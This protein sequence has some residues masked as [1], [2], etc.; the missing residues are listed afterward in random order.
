MNFP[1]LLF[2][3]IT[4]YFTGRGLIQLCK[5]QMRP[6]LL[7]CFSMISGVAI[8]SFLPFFIELLHIPITTGSVS[9]SIG[10]VTLL[11]MIPL[12]GIIK[13]FKMPTFK[14]L[15]G[16]LQLY[17][18][19]FL[20]IFVLLMAL[21]LW[22][23]WYY[24]PNAR[25]MLSGPEVM[26]DFALKEKH[27][28][29]S[30]FHIDLQSTNN[31]LK[32]PFITSLQIIY[33]MFVQPFGQT[34]LSI[35]FVNFIII[36]YTLLK[37]KLHPVI[38]CI[39]L[40]YFFGMPEV[41]GYS[42][43]MLFDYSNMVFFFGGFYFIN[44]YF[45][46]KEMGNFAFSVF[47]FTIATYVR[48]ETLILVGMVLPLIMFHQ[49]K[50]KMPA[51]KSVIRLAVFVFIPF[52]V[53]FLCMNVYVK[54]FIP[55]KYDVSN[56]INKNLGDVSFFFNRVTDMST[57]LIFSDTAGMYYYGYYPWV[58]MFIIVIDIIMVA[59]GSKKFTTE[60]RTFLYGIVM[61]YIGLAFIGYVLPLADLLHTTKRGLF[62]LFPLIL[63]YYRNSPF[64]LM[65]TN[66]VN[67]W[68]YN[69]QDEK[70][71]MPRPT[72]PRPNPVAPPAAKKR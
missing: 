45:E 47:M 57:K 40:L 10:I 43:L 52:I 72:Q 56:D 13:S 70:P 22:R 61:V 69:I 53:Y 44:K 15:F 5:T 55:I 30:L 16:G 71:K 1:G 26:A 64:L 36:V 12:F 49:Y 58:F 48:T 25:D 7:F 63:I 3:L 34:W 65:I 37:E 33:K 67:K 14:D 46:N 29:N 62:K 50:D 9:I 8:F 11:F 39:M 68:E 35:L 31:Y 19:P 24:P 32:P 6:L 20:I 42:Y 60:G 66:S 38:L 28:I 41:F 4:Q 51:A 21:S 59:T 2:L 17:E 27:I 54:H 18:A 23:A